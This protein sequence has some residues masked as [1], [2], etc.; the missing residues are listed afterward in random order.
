MTTKQDIS[1]WFEEGIADNAM[2]MFVICDTYNYEH[3]PVYTISVEEAQK[4]NNKYP[5]NMQSI[6]EIYD[7]RKDKKTQLNNKLNFAKIE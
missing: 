7:L 5:S 4:T 1:N 6:M 3:Y 2:F